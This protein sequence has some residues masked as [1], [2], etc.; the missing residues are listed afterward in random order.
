MVKDIKYGEDPPNYFR[1]RLFFISAVIVF[2]GLI[3]Y[4]LWTSYCSQLQVRRTARSFFVG[5]SAKRAMAVSFF[6]SGR[7]TELGNLATDS[8]IVSLVKKT[9]VIDSGDLEE[10]K[11]IQLS[12][13]C[14]KIFET[15]YTK[16][17]GF[18]QIFAKIAI[19]DGQGNLLADT[20]SECV[21]ISDNDIYAKYASKGKDVSFSAGNI[22][23]VFSI[24]VSMPIVDNSGSLGTV[25]GW[26]RAES[27]FESLRDM[28]S[29]PS[30][31]SD[32]LIVEDI[33]LAISSSS[34]LQS[35]QLLLM[36][37]LGGDWSGVTRLEA[38]KSG[39][40]VDY[41]AISS[42][43]KKTSLN[44]VSLVEEQEIFGNIDPQNLLMLSIVLFLS[45]TG[46]CYYL[47]RS[48]IMRQVYE[49]RISEA[50]RR[51]DAINKQRL[52]LKHEV[53]GRKLADSLRV[54]AESR[55]QEIFDNAP[56]GIFQIDFD[57]R[58]LTVNNA[59]ITLLRYNDA[60]DL[61]SSVTSVR[62]QVFLNRADW[63][64]ILGELKRSGQVVRYEAECVC[65]DGSV[66]WTAGNL[67]LVKPEGETPGYIEGFVVDISS[68]KKIEQKL[69]INQNRLRSLFD[70]SPVALWELDFSKLKEKIDSCDAKN[71][72]DIRGRLFDSMNDVLRN[73]GLIKI[74]SANNLGM[75]F[76][77]VKSR[78]R[79]L[80]TGFSSYLSESSWKYFR[81]IL[82]DLV[83]GVMR[84][85]SEFYY[86]RDDGTEQYFI[87]NCTLIPGYEDS[88]KRVLATVEDI[89]EIKHI[90][91]E[92]RISKEEAQR[93][94]DAKGQFLAN[95]SHEF[96]TPMNSIKGMAQ[97]VETTN[98]SAEQREHIR[99]IKSSV[100][101]LLVI[102]NDILDFSKMG[103]GHMELQ[104]EPL[105]FPPFLKEMR[106]VMDVGAANKELDV[107]LKAEGLPPVI[108]IDS[109]R[110]RQIL[111]NLLG[112][113]I[114]FTSEGT[115]TLTVKMLPEMTSSKK[116]KIYFEISDTGIGLPEEGV[117]SLFKS[118]VQAD[119]SITREFGGT[120]LG[121]AICH[122]LVSLMGGK[123]EA[124]NSP[125]GGA[126]FYFTLLVK[127]CFQENYSDIKA[128]EPER[129]DQVAD[130]SK[131][132]VLVAEDSK[133]NQIL[134]RKIFEKHNIE[135]FTIVEN[136][137]EAVD[138]FIAEEDFDI[139][140]MDL[141]MP[142]MD[143]FEAALAIRK[144]HYPV[145]IVALTANNDDDYWLR[146]K[147]CGMDERITKPFNFDELLAELEKVA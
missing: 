26:V 100:D 65:K 75:E 139:I 109:M 118:F 4:L 39:R 116:R 18:E 124:R 87:V 131:V 51:E 68:R 119:P 33:V 134:L 28:T 83:S 17:L 90:E 144:L 136:G 92:L 69:M 98:L 6:F 34:A 114:K 64:N 79:L 40:T 137:K 111:I 47:V 5:E 53:E 147:Q 94:N 107:V 10:N 106:D 48:I 15:V 93:A 102:V 101:S 72:T 138:A 50:G 25:V 35:G 59:L 24:L 60:D 42:P 135:K 91:K 37:V 82:L 66:L 31:G 99:L 62:N 76:L 45:I 32:F 133:M 74:I 80:E 30:V 88:W 142:V 58:Y 9:D 63:D 120:G 96:R 126:V 143:G 112:N 113:A 128:L 29:S 13:V 55:Y 117:E 12:S 16:F 108:E 49:T 123:L 19:L 115:V 97:L 140:F 67:R 1:F 85:R 38:G 127:E 146:C 54:Q 3:G 36:D 105:E 43:V 2:A 56:V 52:V 145:R 84:H 122:R 110:L 20:D 22:G 27:L 129:L 46:G 95:M 8:D 86:V 73:L 44:V 61:M 11:L 57:G 23:G 21:L 7:M 71:T 70:N 89:S 14:D 132:K 41:L 78:E 141:Q 130:L 103:S 121:L 81:A 125:E 77:G 104:A